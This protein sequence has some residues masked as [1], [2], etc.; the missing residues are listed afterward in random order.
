[1]S[2]LLNKYTI[3]GAIF[4]M[5]GVVLDSMPYWRDLPYEYVRSKGLEPEVEFIKLVYSMSLEQGVNLM[6]TR[7]GLGLSDEQVLREMG[8]IM[9]KPYSQLIDAKPGVEKIL[10]ELT[11]R[12]IHCI[13]AT[14]S[15][16]TLVT[17]ALKRNG[18]LEYFDCIFTSGEVGDSKHDP[19]IYLKAADTLGT[20][21]T[22]TL[23][24]EDSHY[25]LVTAKKAGFVTIGLADPTGAYFRDQMVADAHE[26]Y[27]SMEDIEL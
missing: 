7:Y 25:A 1:M 4:D 20:E 6:N 22:N 5:D 9:M 8:E 15:P 13:V 3:K 24:F 23:V 21:P 10:K 2:K 27:D 17:A 11:S 26:F 19:T 16:R 14:S 12:G 18:L